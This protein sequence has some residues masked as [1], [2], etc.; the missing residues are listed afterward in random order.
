[1]LTQV[2]RL[3]DGDTYLFVAR[4]DAPQHPL[5]SAHA[6]MIGAAMAHAARFAYADALPASAAVPVGVSCRL[7]PREDCGQRAFDRM[8]RIAIDPLP[9]AAA[10]Q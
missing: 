1:M 2:G 8:P 4:A 10:A 6:V 3:P 9:V 7:C 5:Q